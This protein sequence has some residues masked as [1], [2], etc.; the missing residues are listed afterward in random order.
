MKFK[1]F[2]FDYDLAR[3]EFDLPLIIEISVEPGRPQRLNEP[4]EDA[5]IEEVIAFTPRWVEF[6]ITD[7]EQ[8]E[9]IE[10]FWKNL[11]TIAE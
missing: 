2:T 3:G 6:P 5:T 10:Y 1:T 4:A 11:E 7:D 8:D 9:I